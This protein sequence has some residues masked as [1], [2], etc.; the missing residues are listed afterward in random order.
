[1]PGDPWRDE[2]DLDR[3]LPKTGFFRRY[4]DYTQ[5]SEA[6]LAY[7]FFS[8]L[9]GVAATINRRVWLEMGYYKVFPAMG[10]IILGPSGIKKTSSAN[11]VVDLVQSL[12]VTNIYSEKLTPEALIEA[13]RGEN[14]TGLIYAPEMAVFLSKQKYMEGIVPLITRFMDC[15]D[16]WESGTIM[17]GKSALRNVAISSLMCSTVDWFISN[18][19]EDMFGGGFIARNILVLQEHSPRV[20]PIPRPGDPSQREKL[21]HELAHIHTMAGEMY[22]SKE[23]ERRYNDWYGEQKEKNT[24]PEHEILATYYQRK[25]GHIQRIAMCLH[26]AEHQDLEL[27]VSCFDRAVSI[28]EWTEKFLPSMLRQMFKT[29]VGHDQEIILRTLRSVGG[30]IQHSK[31]VHKLQYR[32]NAA[33]IRGHISSL[34]EAGMV[35]EINGNLGHMY[36]LNMEV[37]NG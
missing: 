12:Q 16:Y 9:V 30:S 32:M 29:Q 24:H 5:R 19:P 27:C 25:P 20:E 26:L 23:C 34:K 17:R 36:S 3:L 10:V 37:D 28:L 4:V 21:V 8:A 1:L 15:P 35:H 7:H 13:M 22:M 14:A 2:R 6:P 31:L 11:I 33:Q 18:T